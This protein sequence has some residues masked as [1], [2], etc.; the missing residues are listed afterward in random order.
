V[1]IT[2]MLFRGVHEGYDL[3]QAIEYLMRYPYYIDVDFI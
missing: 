1:P 2:Q 3:K